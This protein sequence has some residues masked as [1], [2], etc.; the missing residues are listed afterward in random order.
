MAGALKYKPMDIA[1]AVKCPQFVAA[2]KNEPASWK[3]GGAVEQALAAKPFA[4]SNKFYD[5]PGETHGFMTRGDTKLEP[6][7]VAIGDVLD[8]ICL[9]V[10]EVTARK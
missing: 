7:R 9:F 6:T 8:K 3:S 10:T 4:A 1:N 2:T 5:Y